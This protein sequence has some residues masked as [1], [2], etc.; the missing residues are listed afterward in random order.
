MIDAEEGI[1]K[2]ECSCMV[3]GNVNSV[4][5]LRRRVWRFLKKINIELPYDP[6]I[7]LLGIYVKKTIIQKDTWDPV[8]TAALFTIARTQKQPKNPKMEEWIMKMWYIYTTEYC[9]CVIRV[10]TQLWPNLC[11]PAMDCNL[12]VSF[13][14]RIF[15]VRILEEA[16][17]SYLRFSSSTR[18]QTHVSCV[19]CRCRKQPCGHGVGQR[20]G[21]D[22]LGE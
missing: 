21:Q 20:G 5:T 13:V 3:G 16:A 1:E 14:H 11:D 9:V 12:L 18:D 8:F 10:L 6:A 7:L 4:Q 15:Q 2:R 19:S 22:K 17:I